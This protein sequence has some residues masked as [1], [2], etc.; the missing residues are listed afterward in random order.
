MDNDGQAAIQEALRRRAGLGA[1]SA[2]IPGGASAANANTPSNPLA[3]NGM[4]PPTPTGQ[5]AMPPAPTAENPMAGAAHMLDNAQPNE[6]NI[7]LK[8]MGDR[9]KKL[10]VAGE[11]LPML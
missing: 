3:Q 9:L 8:Y 2:G 1:S 4:V 11:P 5:G 7:I 6:A 10:P